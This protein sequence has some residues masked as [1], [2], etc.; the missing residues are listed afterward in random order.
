[1]LINY[2]K[3][4]LPI[5]ILFFLILLYFIPL[6][7]F[8]KTVYAGDFTGSDLTELNLP[9]RYILQESLKNGKIPLWTNLIA[10][11]F[12]LL[13]E[14]QTGVLYPLNLILYSLF[15]FPVAFNLG[16]ILNF[17]LAG[18]FLFVY[19]RRLNIS[20]WGALLAAISFSLGGF[21][22]FKIKH[23]NFINAA[24]WLPLIFY[25]IETYFIVKKRSL[26]VLGLILVLA[27]QFFAGSP[28]IFYIT[29]ISA[30]L[31]FS[32]KIFYFTKDF[33]LKKIAKTI[34]LWA[35]IGLILFGIVAIQ[36]LP[37][38]IN[39]RQAER[40][41]Q[42]S[43]N[44][45]K[46]YHYN[47]ICLLFFINPYIF[48][49]PAD[50]SYTKTQQLGIFWENN[51]YFGILALFFSL[52]AIF[53]LG[54]K[55]RNVKIFLILILI[56]FLF[57]FG[58]YSPVFI[59][60]WNILPGFKMFRFPQRFL[61]LTLLCLATLAGF[62]FDFVLMKVKEWMNKT[63][64]IIKSKILLETLLPILIILISTFD[65]FLVGINYLGILDYEEYFKAPK[66]VEFLKQD[67]DFFRIY[68]FGWDATWASIDK[69]SGG[70][71]NNLS[72]FLANQELIPPNINVFWNVESIDDRAAFEGGMLL[73]E[74]SF[75]RRRMI[76]G[77]KISDNNSLF[78]VSDEAINLLS[79]QN[80][81]Y[82]LSFFSLKNNNLK[83]VKEINVDFLP[84]L[85]I[86]ENN[87]FIPRIF[88]VFNTTA[89]NE[90]QILEAISKNFKPEE[91]LILGQ[92]FNKKNNS[93]IKPKAKIEIKNYQ[94]DL[95]E[96]IA[97]FNQDGFLYLSNTFDPGW[98]AFINGTKIPILKANYAFQAI[99]VPSG[100]HTVKFKFMPKSYVI[101]RAISLTTLIVISIYF[102]LLLLGMMQKMQK[103]I[104]KL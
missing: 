103:P 30:F 35:V 102:I 16:I 91:E 82:I 10:D 48:G 94:A 67:N 81:K 5:I 22:V 32:F 4:S 34:F 43:Y 99:Q 65:L 59:V 49:N 37:T 104:K 15:D 78:N 19:A 42:V 47:P 13:A 25:L 21:F 73:K 97:D 54:L 87:K 69:L 77:F 31:Y 101:G 98:Q 96:V 86:Y 36:L 95:I 23:V 18:F 85:K 64:K 71:K 12:P 53:C 17:F 9:F 20:N 7:T 11:G 72:L 66:S 89:I 14:G 1:M 3:K 68:S 76:W 45:I 63:G 55:N 74:S 28:P 79:I 44:D 80:V 41:L 88:G 62:G 58:E 92:N 24:I 27:I 100:K 50:F 39:S 29:I 56:S 83:L 33:F 51:V 90:P 61:L 40:G 26:V 46:A 84:T 6:L 75:L 8:K 2:L 93:N 70:W 38:Y 60:F 52:V 57:I